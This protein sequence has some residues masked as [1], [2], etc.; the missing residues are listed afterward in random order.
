MPTVTATAT[1]S[2]TPTAAASL[3]VAKLADKVHA[4]PGE[5]LQYTLAVMNDM[6]SSE[7]PGSYVRLLD[8]LPQD[9]E[10]VVGSLSA[11]ATY[12]VQTRSILWGGQVPRGQSL[13]VLFQARLTVTAA[14]KRSVINTVLVTDA[15][16]RESVASAQTHIVRPLLTATPAET[17]RAPEAGYRLYLPLAYKRVP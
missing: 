12:E 13:E 10:L 9:L 11:H 7:D 2:A 14:T 1:P 15:F 4:A 16:G 6:L 8:Q 3:M 5:V 17:A